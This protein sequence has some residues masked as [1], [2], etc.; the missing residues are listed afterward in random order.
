MIL[1]DLSAARWQDPQLNAKQVQGQVFAKGWWQALSI[2]QVNFDAA[3][4]LAIEVNK[5]LL[6]TCQ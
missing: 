5:V 2:M 4:C 3:Q 6:Y 1:K